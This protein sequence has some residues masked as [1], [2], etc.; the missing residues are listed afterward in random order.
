MSEP[1]MAEFYQAEYRRM[2]Q[3]NENPISRD[4]ATQT[5]RSQSLVGFIKPEVTTVTRCL[6]IGCSTGL[7]LQGYREKYG[8]Q[9][10]GIEPGEAYR[11]YA[12]EQGLTVYASLEELEGAG[13]AGFDLISM[14]HVLEHLPDPAGYL[15]HLRT[16]LLAAGGWLLLEVPNLYA[17]DSFEVAHLY[18]F[19]A[20]TLTETLR[21]AGLEPV[22][23]EKHGRP[24]SQL[25]PLYIS[26][27]ARPTAPAQAAVRPEKLISFKRKTGM[28]R[29]RIV[30]RLFPRKAWLN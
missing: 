10:V 28:L 27:L 21:K 22:K 16:A 9:P 2:Y 24:R 18:S 25:L 23:L 15:D 17:H 29:R 5:A 26:V 1:E 7:I 13:E 30:E 8:C 6:D 12:H 4:F 11:K 3:G 14:S 19:S 20:H